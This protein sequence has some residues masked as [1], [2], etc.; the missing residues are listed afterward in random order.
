MIRW[1]IKI[2]YMQETKWIDKSREI[3]ITNI[4]RFSKRY[5]SK[6]Y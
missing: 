5:V 3:D 6:I 4:F 2:V 1:K